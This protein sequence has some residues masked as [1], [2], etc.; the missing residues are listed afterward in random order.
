[1][2][3]F[4]IEMLGA[5]VRFVA[6][7]EDQT[8]PVGPNFRRQ[9][10]LIFKEAVHNAARHANCARLEIEIKLARSGLTLTIQ[11][12]GAGFDTNRD[13]DG[14]GLA[15]MRTRAKNL[16]GTVEVASGSQ[17]TTITLTVPW[18]R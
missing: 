2:R 12:D 17:G 7:G 11:D 18:A 14:Q 15:S 16:S 9:V 1:M 3:Q 8:R 10:F 4:A 6:S 5:R 13:S